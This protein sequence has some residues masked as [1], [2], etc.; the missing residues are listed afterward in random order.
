MGL[1]LVLSL[2]KVAM[3]GVKIVGR[4]GFMVF[5]LLYLG[6]G[7]GINRKDR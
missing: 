2:K 3:I 4:S 7:V 6:F 5:V 1:L